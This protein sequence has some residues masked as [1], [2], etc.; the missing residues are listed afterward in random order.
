M[1]RATEG[2]SAAARTQM[3][4][5]ELLSYEDYFLLVYD[6][7]DLNLKILFCLL[8]LFISFFL[9]YSVS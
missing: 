5:S 8:L 7:F 1:L 3:T 6:T 4:F 2:V 9:L